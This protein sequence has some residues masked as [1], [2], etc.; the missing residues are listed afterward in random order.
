MDT[1]FFFINTNGS[2]NSL[3]KK[4]TALFLQLVTIAITF[5]P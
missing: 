5:V 2:E 3:K 1:L 4:K